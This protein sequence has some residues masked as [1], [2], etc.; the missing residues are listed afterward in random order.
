MMTNEKSKI[1]VAGGLGYE[2]LDKS[3]AVQSAQ[4]AFDEILEA[5]KFLPNLTGMMANHPALLNTYWFGNG[6][7]ENDKLFT[8]IEQQV[9]FLVTSYENNCHYCVAAHSSIGK[10][11]GVPDQVINAIREGNVI[12]DAKLEALSKYAKSTVVN[13]GRVSD[14]D[15][16]AFL[17]AGYSKEHMLE[18]I[19]IVSLKVLTNYLNYLA[20]TP[21][22]KQFLAME[23]KP[24]E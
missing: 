13:R 6:Y 9:L 15:I 12:P 3:T 8:H 24:R 20:K 14:N 1:V 4:R 22:D 19:V 16:E 23:W 10:M 5:Y 21:V 2:V 11:Y 18:V 17:N 7:L